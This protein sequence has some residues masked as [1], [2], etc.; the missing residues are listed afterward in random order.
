MKLPRRCAD[1]QNPDR[2]GTESRKGDRSGAA[3]ARQQATSFDRTTTA[4]IPGDTSLADGCSA[5]DVAEAGPFFVSPSRRLVR[6]LIRPF[7]GWQVSSIEFAKVERSVLY[8]LKQGSAVL[9]ELNKEMNL[10]MVEKLM[11]DTAEGI[12]YQEVSLSTLV[13]SS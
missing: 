6:E 5:G 9:K 12:A 3:Q 2:S 4:E 11:S 13:T 1:Y 8:G 7:G 10:D